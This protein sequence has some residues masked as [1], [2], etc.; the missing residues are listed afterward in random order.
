M[1]PRI[2]LNLTASGEFEIWINEKGRDLLVQEMQR[3]SENN[4]HFHLGPVAIGEVEVSSR[5]YRPDDKIVEYGKVLFRTDE[6]DQQH[7][8][9]VLDEAS[10]P[11]SN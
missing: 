5:P 7:F 1:K 4:D 9:H 8:P 10:Q 11:R 3:L 6:W 2:T